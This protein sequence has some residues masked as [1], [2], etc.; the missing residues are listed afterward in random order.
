M[1]HTYDG[2]DMSSD[3]VMTAFD[4]KKDA[5]EFVEKHETNKKHLEDLALKAKD[6]HD[7][8]PSHKFPYQ[9]YVDDGCYEWYIDGYLYQDL[10]EEFRTHLVKELFAKEENDELTQDEYTILDDKD[11]I[12][13]FKIYLKNTYPIY[14]DEVIEATIL[15]R[16]SYECPKLETEELGWL[17]IH[18]TTLHTN[19]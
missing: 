14:S 11:C 10:R 3:K 8:Y 7:A 6:F 2:I 19:G 12:E 1:C 15:V 9:E 13:D 4:E 16:D 17:S 18:E 5:E